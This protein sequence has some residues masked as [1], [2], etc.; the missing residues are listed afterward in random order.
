MA[1]EFIPVI[2]FGFLFL[3]VSLRLT[4][5]GAFGVIKI[6]LMLSSIILIGWGIF[7]GWAEMFT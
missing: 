2:L 7:T 3:Y 6:G 5:S 1:Y 4:N